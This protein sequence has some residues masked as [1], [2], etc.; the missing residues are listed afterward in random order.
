MPSRPFHI[1]QPAER[2]TCVIFASPH[3]GREYPE[4]FLARAVVGGTDI[5]SSED[6][7]VDRLI[8]A[9]PRHGAPLLLADVPRAYVDLNRSAEELDPAIVEGARAV[10]HNP[11]IASGLGVIPRVVAGGRALYRG[12]IPL[13]EAHQRIAT[14]WRPYHAQLGA[15][16]KEAQER[17]G[18]AILIDCHSMPHEAVDG[19]ARHG[20][21]RPDVVLGDRFG[22]AAGAA[23]VERVEA[24]F[25]RAGLVTARNAPF[26]GAYTVQHYGRPLRNQ[27]VIQVEIDRSLYMD[28]RRV[29]PNGDF[30]AFV[31]VMSGVVADIAL[32]GAAG[33]GAL[34]A[35]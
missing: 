15:L 2:N 28:E 3:S 10:A 26:A 32:I 31:R 14:C 8:A 5:R 23:V 25:A 33:D 17:F 22:A 4:D 16:M 13:S 30:D 7:Y 34:A 24:A 29:R 6:A 11:R 12:K 9:A 21:K 19:V 35:E 20:A 27:H 1:V 18:Q